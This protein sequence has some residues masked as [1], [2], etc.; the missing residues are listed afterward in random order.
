MKVY[1]NG[2]TSPPNA[3]MST[4]ITSAGGEVVST[5]DDCTLCICGPNSPPPRT[6]GPLK[7]PIVKSEVQLQDVSKITLPVHSRL[8]TTLGTFRQKYI[9]SYQT[10]N[11]NTLFIT[12]S[13]L[14]LDHHLPSPNKLPPFLRVN[15]V[16][17]SKK[18][19]RTIST[20]KIHFNVFVNS[21]TGFMVCD[22]KVI[23][24]P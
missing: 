9:R 2:I 19:R 4:I 1:I 13:Y 14:Y 5:Y 7:S 17:L 12:I 24:N 22:W 21:S 23:K 3:E 20:Q 8:S 15:E 18:L 11:M 6:K 16:F 10:I